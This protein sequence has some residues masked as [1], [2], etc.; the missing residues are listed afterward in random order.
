MEFSIQKYISNFVENQFPQFYQDE[1]ENFILFLKAYYEWMEKDGNPIGEARNLFDYGDI[2]NTISIPGVEDFLVHFQQKY[3]YGIPY[4]VITSKK[5]LLKHILDVYRSKGSIQCYKLLFRLIYDEDIDVYLPGKDILRASDGT[6]VESKYVEVTNSDLLVDYV[7]KTIIGVSSGTTAVVE[8]YVT[9][10]FNRDILNI[11]YLSH[12]EPLGGNFT[13]GEAILLINEKDNTDLI[14]RAPIVLGSLETL[15]IINGGQNFKIGDIIKIARKDPDTGEIISFGKE[16]LLKVTSLTKGVG[17]IYFDVAHPGFGFTTNALCF[18]YNNPDD[19]SGRGAGFQVGTIATTRQLDYNT[20]LV[21]SYANTT[22]DA[23]YY[24]FPQSNTANLT[25][26]IAEALT[27]Q[28][29]VF[30]SI[31]SLG[32][33][34]TGN[35]YVQPANVFVRSTLLSQVLPGNVVY[36]STHSKVYSIQVSP[37]APEHSVTANTSGVNSVAET[38]LVKNANTKF[39]INDRVYYK[40]PSGNTAIGGLIGNSYYYVTFSNNSSFAVSEILGGANVDLTESRV[41]AGETHTFKNDNTIV[42]L[43][44]N[45]DIITVIN[46]D[47]GSNAYVSIISNST[48]GDLRLTIDDPGKEFVNHSANIVV[49]N[50][51]GG[52]SNG[53]GLQFSASYFPYVNGVN[54]KFDYVFSKFSTPYYIFANT[55]GVSNTDNVIYLK[56]AD[57]KFAVNDKIIYTVPT[58]NTAISGIT[59]NTFYISFVNSTSFALSNTLGGSNLDIT[60]SRSGTAEVHT[61]AFDGILAAN[62]ADV[63]ALTA[64]T[65]LPNTEEFIVVRQVVNSTSMFLFGNTTNNSTPSAVYKVAPAILPSNFSVYESIMYRPDGTINGLN[66]VI[67]AF[68]NAGNNIVGS[69]KVFNSGVGYV[70]GEQVKAFLYGAVSNNI[71]I[72]SGGNNY[73]NGDVIIFSGGDPGTVATGYVTVNGNGTIIGTI[74]TNPGS[75]YAYAPVIRVRTETG[76]GAVL[77]AE[78]TE[79]NRSSQIDGRIVKGGVGKARGYWSTTRGFLNSDKYIQDSH[80]YQD[81][82]YEIRVARSLDKYKDILY[83]TFHSTGSELFGEF[84]LLNRESSNVTIL[85]EQSEA[86]TTAPTYYLI[87]SDNRITSDSN[88]TSITVD[89]Y[90]I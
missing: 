44:D 48:G 68:P 47:G 73:V 24:N 19:V 86:N 82:S 67:N 26:T 3:L 69:V 74:L 15:S 72:V 25:S 35:G 80:Y 5:F 27:Y 22:L 21:F 70:D 39:R 76:S 59:G 90:F 84:L 29:N 46:N 40:V 52:S 45:T 37:Y 81:Y 23:A 38:I 75:G 11:V 43:Y 63:I 30:G 36:N 85:Y 8:N 12:I 20:D 33:I 50:S 14:N 66:E 1:G 77:E 60:E 4:N 83:N 89:K 41:G 54:T 87:A 16:G 78:L 2:D 57:S 32:S 42:A 13:P 88:T 55:S 49:S 31:F 65:L 53:F 61:V 56:N 79:F 9:E 7:G 71:S 64:N 34:T 51:S 62:G 10:S 28:N 58:N 18:V 17:T 6:W